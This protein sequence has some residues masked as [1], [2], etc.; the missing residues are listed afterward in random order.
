MGALGDGELAY[1]TRILREGFLVFVWIGTD[2]LRDKKTLLS[3]Y[4][5][6]RVIQ[7]ISAGCARGSHARE[8]SSMPQIEPK[9]RRM[10]KCKPKG[11]RINHTVQVREADAEAPNPGTAIAMSVAESA[12]V[13]LVEAAD[14]DMRCETCG[15]GGTLL[16]ICCD[17][18]GA[19]CASQHH[20]ACAGVH[21]LPAGGW[22]CRQCSIK[23]RAVASPA[24][25]YVP[26]QPVWVDCGH[27]LRAGTW[28]ER[29]E[30][31]VVVDL[32]NPRNGDVCARVRVIDADVCDRFPDVARN[33]MGRTWW[34]QHSLDAL[35]DARRQRRANGV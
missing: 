35:V 7:K 28:V 21:E 4:G 2:M 18:S 23:P 15:E 27:E 12:A 19:G 20:L 9:G 25:D 3:L 29:V 13:V 26:G 34:R 30:G 17:R 10:K 6:S 24:A 33:L 14:G 5:L 16:L 31:G 1:A 11:K 32:E 22:L 8:L